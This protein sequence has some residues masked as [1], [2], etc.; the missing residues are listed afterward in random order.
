MDWRG[1]GGAAIGAFALLLLH[2]A[3]GAPAA[4]GQAPAPAGYSALGPALQA[5]LQTGR[6]TVVVVTAQA[7]PASAALRDAL[8]VLL[9]TQP[10]G[11]VAM[12]AEM[13]AELHADRVRALGV[14]RLPAVL[15]YGRGAGG[16]QLVGHKLG[17]TDPYQVTGWLASLGLER[18]AIAAADP[19][20]LRTGGGYPSTQTPSG[21]APPPPYVP[22]AP[23]PQSPP[24]MMYVPQQ[25]VQM[26]P[27]YA[28]PSPAP[29]VVAPP[30]QP[31]VVAQPPQTIMV[32]PAPPPNI[33][34][35][36]PTQPTVMMAPVASAPPAAAPTNAFLAPSQPAAAPV[37]MM[38][39]APAAAPVAMAP[40][41][42]P[43]AMAPQQVGQGPVTAAFMTLVAPTLLE[44][45]LGS[46]GQHFAQKGQ[47]RLAMGQAP[48]MSN[49][50]MA[51]T[52]MGAAPMAMMAPQAPP[53]YRLVPISAYEAAPPAYGPPPGYGYGPPAE[54]YPPPNAPSPQGYRSAPA[55]RKHGW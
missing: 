1:R 5:T 13:P 39:M 26:A 18:A 27:T 30:S 19:T 10:V 31:V 7:E 34:F 24:P 55:P 25:Q 47:P 21:Q 42:A 15:V 9:R 43:V 28:A 37:A 2:A 52:A 44:R 49:V 16:M 8:P 36:A 11:A 35:S 54:A 29:L 50:A 22:Q 48:T 23:P 4:R 45:L 6:P 3:P 38:A 14:S 20:V 17:A 32:A 41:P 53:G 40:A 12:L 51:P 46:I 33:V